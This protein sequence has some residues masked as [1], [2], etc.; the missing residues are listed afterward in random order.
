MYIVRRKEATFLHFSLQFF[1]CKHYWSRCWSRWEN[2]DRFQRQFQPIKF[3]NL[4]VPSPANVLWKLRSY[5]LNYRLSLGRNLPVVNFV[6]FPHPLWILSWKPKYQLTSVTFA[7]ACPF[8]Q[9]LRDWQQLL[10]LMMNKNKLAL[11]CSSLL[12][13]FSYT[14]RSWLPECSSIDSILTFMYAQNWR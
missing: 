1:H 3:M 2:L 10:F 9:T 13:A 5:L 4:G 12:P 6:K 7:L 11:H 14:C 8:K